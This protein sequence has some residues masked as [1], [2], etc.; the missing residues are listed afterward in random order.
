MVKNTEYLFQDKE[1][2][3]MK[4]TCVCCGETIPEGRQ[5]CP[6]CENGSIKDSGNRTEFGTGAVLAVTKEKEDMT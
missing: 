6:S 1:G 2:E 5:V 4:D 3:M